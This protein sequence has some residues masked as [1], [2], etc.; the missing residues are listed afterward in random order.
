A[1]RSSASPSSRLPPSPPAVP[2]SSSTASRVPDKPTSRPPRPGRS[3]S[4]PRKSTA[5]RSRLPL[6]FD[7]TRKGDRS[8]RERGST[9]G[10]NGRTDMRSEQ[11][12]A[13]ALALGLASLV[14]AAGAQ[15]FK[16]KD[17]EGKVTYTDVP[18]LRSET[19]SIVDTR[20]SAN[21]ADHSSI[22]K[23]AAR[24]PSSA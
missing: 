9:S 2:D 13:T 4:R 7:R 23:E 16:C 21:V 1:A 20:A 22:R 5:E 15:V 24:L 17:A 19:G 11:K 6:P 3:S 14:P 8:P 12:F 18:C 10:G